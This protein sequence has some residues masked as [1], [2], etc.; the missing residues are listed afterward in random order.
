MNLKVNIAGVEFDN[1]IMTASGT[2]GFGREYSE[3]FNLDELG[4]ICVK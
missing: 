2:F 4:A 3:Y 1:P